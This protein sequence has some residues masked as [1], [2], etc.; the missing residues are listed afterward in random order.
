MGKQHLPSLLGA[1]C[2]RRVADTLSCTL[3][4]DDFDQMLG[5]DNAMLL[6]RHG[7]WER[8]SQHTEAG[9]FGQYE[10]MMRACWKRHSAAKVIRLDDVSGLL[11]AMRSSRERSRLR[12]LVLVRHPADM[13]A[14][15]LVIPTFSDV[16]GGHNPGR[17]NELGGSFGV[18]GSMCAHAQALLVREGSDLTFRME[19][20]FSNPRLMLERIYGVVG[21][22]NAS[23]RASEAIWKARDDQCAATG[24]TLQLGPSFRPR[25]DAADICSPIEGERLA[26]RDSHQRV[27]DH[28]ELQLRQ[29]RGE[30]WEHVRRECSGLLSLHYPEATAV[31]SPVTAGPQGALPRL[32]YKLLES[33]V[34]VPQHRLLI[35]LVEKNGLTAQSVLSADLLGQHDKTDKAMTAGV[36]IYGP[37]GFPARY[38]IRAQYDAMRKSPVEHMATA[39][40]RLFSP[41]WRKV[42]VVRHP[43]E[44]FVSAYRSKCVT[45]LAMLKAGRKA[46]ARCLNVFRLRFEDVSMQAVAERL[47]LGVTDP[48]WAPQSA[49]CGGLGATAHLYERVMH[50]DMAEA[51]PHL[52]RRWGFPAAAVA[53]ASQV[54]RTSC[55]P[56]R[57]GKQFSHRTNTSLLSLETPNTSS[58]LVLEAATRRLV[59]W[60]YRDDFPLIG[61]PK[62][63]RATNASLLKTE[64]GRDGDVAENP[65]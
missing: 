40:A 3:S 34:P 29:R 42:V 48:H 41:E 11:D 64:V 47:H 55:K 38:T 4:F 39:A 12:T 49:F 56:M 24:Q 60:F 52:L 1:A 28:G 62:P 14:S 25:F 35:C 2:A 63:K 17:E 36:I 53:R 65:P 7:W 8:H 32:S 23:A 26:I 51:L 13:A 50:D 61:L 43:V 30:L 59:E 21:L 20:F 18:V 19:D 22:P 9:S 37:D 57:F 16:N 6:G 31:T 5:D 45:E 33:L 15:R 27:H 54:L 44:R 46:E 10:L 58:G